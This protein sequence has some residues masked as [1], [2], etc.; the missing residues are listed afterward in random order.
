[1]KE[2]DNIDNTNININNTTVSNNMN[3]DDTEISQHNIS[4]VISSLINYLP[5]ISLIIVFIAIG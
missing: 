4:N 3:I 5:K 2:S 1:M